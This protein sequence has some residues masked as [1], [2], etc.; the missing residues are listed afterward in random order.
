MRRWIPWA[1]DAARLIEAMDA[2][3]C[4]FVGNSQGGFIALRL[5]ARRPDL[6]LS[7]T[8]LGSSGE[9]EKRTQEFA[10]LVNLSAGAG[11]W[12]ARVNRRIHHVW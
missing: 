2:G 6:L 12:P 1:E 10:L 8:I 9:A 5:A 3:P 7:C 11:N 4:H